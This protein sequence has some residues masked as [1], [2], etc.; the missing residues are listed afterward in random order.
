MVVNFGGLGCISCPD[1]V[2]VLD[3]P[4]QYPPTLWEQQLPRDREVGRTRGDLIR[5]TA[6]TRLIFTEGGIM[7]ATVKGF[8]KSTL[9]LTRPFGSPIG[10]PPC[11]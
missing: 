11:T 5:I 6:F 7:S 2:Q 3:V 1:I 8:R 9:P 10:V 4:G